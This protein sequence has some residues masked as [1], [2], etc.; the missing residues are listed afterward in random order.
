MSLPPGTKLTQDQEDIRNSII[1]VYGSPLSGSEQ[2]QYARLLAEFDHLVKYYMRSETFTVVE[3]DQT[4]E[5][6]V[7]YAM[8]KGHAGPGWYYHTT[9]YPDEGSVGAFLSKE[10][11]MADAR[12]ESFPAKKEA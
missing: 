12:K 9:D 1:K 6:R 11:A 7:T 2:R 3:G 10:A 5:Y 4:V 8:V